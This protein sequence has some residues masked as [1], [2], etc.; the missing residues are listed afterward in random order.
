MSVHPDI[1]IHWTDS[2]WAGR[3]LDS[4]LRARYVYRLV[5]FYRVGLRLTQSKGDIQNLHGALNAR[6]PVSPRKRL[7]F[8]ELR[9]SQVSTHVANFGSL[10][11]GFRRR[12]LLEKGANPVFYVPNAPAGVANTNATKLLNMAKG[13]PE[14]EVLASFIKPMSRRRSK[15]VLPAYDEMEWRCVDCKVASTG[16]R[17]YPEREGHPTFEFEPRDVV[18]LVFPDAQTRRLAIND[19]RLRP[20][21]RKHVPMMFDVKDIKNL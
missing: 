12:F 19:E 17:P 6:Q 11:I 20:F 5:E 21:F 13:D 15:S 3:P 8:T 2:R 4:R 14:L 9:L 16:A 1:L 7:C 10:G 18:L